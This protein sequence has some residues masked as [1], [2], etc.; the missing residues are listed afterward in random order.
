MAKA[1][2]NGQQKLP[3][4]PA[5]QA[6]NSLHHCHDGL[7]EF[8]VA[9]PQPRWCLQGA[10]SW[11]G[12]GS[13][14]AVIRPS[15]DCAARSPQNFSACLNLNRYGEIA[16]RLRGAQRA[17]FQEEVRRAHESAEWAAV[18][19]SATQISA[20]A[21]RRTSSETNSHALPME[22]LY[23]TDHSS[24]KVSVFARQASG[25]F[26]VCHHSEGP[27]RFTRRYGVRRPS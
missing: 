2:G 24:E 14:V 6:E 22:K 23:K 7:R 17:I 13:D 20:A 12:S 15:G 21:L 26:E 16:D 11:P 25:S 27:S 3:A 4:A 5:L 10:S 1:R 19:S 8:M 9:L 18:G